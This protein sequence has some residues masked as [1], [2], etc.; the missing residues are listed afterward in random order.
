MKKLLKITLY[1]VVILVLLLVL[2]GFLASKFIDPNS[3]KAKITATVQEKTG[4]TLVMNGDISL[5][6]FPWIGARVHDVRLSNAPGFTP[7]DNF[8]SIGEADVR[9]KVLPLLSRKVEVARVVVRDAEINLAKNKAGVTNWQDLIAGKTPQTPAATTSTTSQASSFAVAISV[10]GVD[11]E[12]ANLNWVDQQKGQNIALKNLQLISD[13]PGITQSFPVNLSFDLVSNQAGQ[14]GHFAFKSSVKVDEAASN[15]QLNDPTFSFKPAQSGRELTLKASKVTADLQKQTAAIEKLAVSSGDLNAKFSTIQA[16]QILTQPVFQGE[17]QVGNFNLKNFLAAMG[18][19]IGTQDANALQKVS[20]DAKF[21]GTSR[22]LQLNP[23]KIQ[24]D[25]ST[26]Q[27]N[28]S[29]TDFATHSMNFNLSVNQL[30]VDRYLPPTKQASNPAGAVA[31]APVAAKES[32]SNMQQTTINGELRVASLTVAQTA[33]SQVYAR[34]NMAN[35]VL[36]VNPLNANVYG[37]STQGKVAIDLR[38][39][40]PRY[41]IDEQLSNIDM[42]QLVK[43][44]KLT[45]RANLTTHVSMQGADKAAMMRSLN[46][47]LNFNIQNGAYVGKNIPYEIDRAEALFKRQ[48]APAQPAKQ[49]TDFSTF[50]GSGVFNNGVFT[51]ND[52]LVQASNFKIT[53]NGVANLVTETMNYHV[54]FVG[55]HTVTNAQGQSVQEERQTPIPVVISGSFSSPSVQPDVAAFLQSEAGQK[56]IQKGVE[57]LREHLG[58]SGGGKLGGALQQFLQQ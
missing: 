54:K 43:S 55:V 33:L 37:G 5:S 19:P 23:L 42:T 49:Q 25:D 22:S 6:F 12:N 45:G 56:A 13:S 24:L 30:N 29:I 28:F 39:A 47:S 14:S 38:S 15:Y 50:Q 31:A 32:G 26:L 17:V 44:G 51:N 34:I 36:N 58:G 20:L 27:G 52:L 53:G 1:V 4:R 46:G 57:K 9:V 10:A 21:Q 11:I 18:K 48:P 35:G 40:A 2:A 41:T 3:L 8:A 7:Q 16:Q